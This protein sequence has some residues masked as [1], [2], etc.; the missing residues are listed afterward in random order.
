MTIQTIVRFLLEREET[1]FDFLNEFTCFH[2]VFLFVFRPLK[3]VFVI[4][5]Y[6]EVLY[7][8]KES[9]FLS[10][11]FLVSKILFNLFSGR[12]SKKRPDYSSGLFNTSEL[13]DFIARVDPTWIS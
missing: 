12:F 5:K 9:K 3:V 11:P 13:T 2:D 1:E 7:I 6:N 8:L 4:T 10:T